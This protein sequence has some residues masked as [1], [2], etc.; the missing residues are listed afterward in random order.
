MSALSK[1]ST[2]I[3][4]FWAGGTGGTVGGGGGAG[5]NGAG[6]S[7]GRTVRPRISV[8][9]VGDGG[10]C[11][12][13]PAAVEGASGTG[14]GAIS[15]PGRA[16]AGGAGAG[17]ARAARGGGMEGVVTGGVLLPPPARLGAPCP[18]RRAPACV[19]G[20]DAVYLRHC[21]EG[22]AVGRGAGGGGRAGSL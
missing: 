15:G 3:R 11:A 9:S 22:M 14:I 8:G 13:G 16:A 20:Q 17:L 2:T 18:L 19:Q 7:A 5:G 12:T 21:R 6:G 10:A 1:F 4:P